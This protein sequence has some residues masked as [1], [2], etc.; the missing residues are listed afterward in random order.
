MSARSAMR[1][2]S[3]QAA[4][5]V[6]YAAELGERPAA[7]GSEAAAA[8]E[9]GADPHAPDARAEAA[10]ERVALHFELPEGARAFAK[11]LAGGVAGERAALDALLERHLRGWRLER[12]AAV[13]RNL[14]R[15][16]AWELRHGA[17]PAEV[18]IDEAVSLAHRFGGD[19]SPG[20]VN[21]V[22]DAVARE[23]GL[24]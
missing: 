24:P 2:R 18:V 3:R 14:L 22:L 8:E 15:L 20:F 21:A 13:D 17:T 7:A 1:H 16:G 4:L 23:R 19:K 9:G 5:Q 6:L 10:F 11:E 12:L